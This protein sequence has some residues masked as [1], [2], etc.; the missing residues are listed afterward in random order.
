MI[1]PTTT[2]TTF[3][4]LDYFQKQLTYYIACPNQRQLRIKHIFNLHTQKMYF[5][6]YVDI[7][8]QDFKNEGVVL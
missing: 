4:Y 8:L 1:K 6:I 7:V 2:T 5:L 3:V